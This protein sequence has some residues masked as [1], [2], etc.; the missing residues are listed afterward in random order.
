M[1][2]L[3]E[4][5]ENLH[6]REN[7]VMGLHDSPTPTKTKKKHKYYT[8]YSVVVPQGIIGTDVVVLIKVF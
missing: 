5:T 6:G 2:T 1:D 4:G 8:T 7:G 3:H